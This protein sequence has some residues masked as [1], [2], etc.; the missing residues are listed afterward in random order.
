MQIESELPLLEWMTEPFF[1]SV[2]AAACRSSSHK[3]E[4]ILR[5]V[6]VA[7]GTKQGENFA[8]AIYR[9]RLDFEHDY[10]MQHKSLIVK[11]NSANELIS[12]MIATLGAD[13]SETYF[14]SRVMEAI[15]AGDSEAVKFAPR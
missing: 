11:T 4:P 6:Q 10:L 15:G 12:H 1:A 7:A 9:C 5:R 8:A 3:T 13:R 14:Y 2:L